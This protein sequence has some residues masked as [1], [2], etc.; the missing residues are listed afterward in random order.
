[1]S[2]DRNDAAAVRICDGCRSE[3]APTFLACPRCGRLVHAETLKALAADAEAAERAGDSA[4]ALAVWRQALALLPAGS[5]Q[6]TRITEKV[7]AFVDAG[8]SEFVLWFR[9]YPES[10]SL[11]AMINDVAPKIRA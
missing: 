7:Q 3:L 10:A 2:I 9:D 1:M 6:H 8:C 11:E 4:R 5:G